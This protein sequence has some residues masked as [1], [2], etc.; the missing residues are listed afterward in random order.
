MN[1]RKML[2]GLM[3]LAALIGGIAAA[4][5]AGGRPL[6]R[7]NGP[8]NTR[9]GAQGVLWHGNDL[10]AGE[11]ILLVVGGTF[12]TGEEAEAA[13]E[14]ILIGDL[15]GYYVARTEQFVGL[16]DFLGS[17]ANDYVLV[18]AFRTDAGAHEF[19]Q[20]ARAAGAPAL[21]SPRLEN[22]GDVYVGLGQEA[23]PNGS[24]PLIGP[25]RGVST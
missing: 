21:P 14:Q 8:T 10:G 23:H 17:T 18:T 19:L 11:R 16:R 1:T 13:N 25:L 9:L 24:G 12:S 15:Q 4:A 5:T 7:V 6:P 22:R 2:I 20:V 3:F